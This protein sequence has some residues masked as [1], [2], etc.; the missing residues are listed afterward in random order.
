MSITVE[1]AREDVAT[2]A[3]LTGR[4]DGPAAPVLDQELVPLVVPGAKLVLDLTDLAY[5]SSAGLRIFLKTAKQAKAAK[6]R[7]SLFGINDV[8]QEVFDISGFTAIFEI[9]ENRDLALAALR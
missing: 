2:I 6:A 3:K 1:I 5:V 9:H 4:L 7:L 8:V